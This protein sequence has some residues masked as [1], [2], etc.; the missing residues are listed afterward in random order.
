MKK[1]TKWA[2]KRKEEGPL[3]QLSNS[4]MNTIFYFPNGLLGGKFPRPKLK[5]L[6]S[7]LYDESIR[8]GARCFLGTKDGQVLVIS[9]KKV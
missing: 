1:K 7:L 3:V 5:D 8:F 2:K 4:I 6:M 9:G